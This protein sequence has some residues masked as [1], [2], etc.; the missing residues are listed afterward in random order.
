M[1]SKEFRTNFEERKFSE[2][3]SRRN[4][5]ICSTI[6]ALIEFEVNIQTAASAVEREVTS[7]ILLMISSAAA[8][9]LVI[10][11]LSLGLDKQPSG[12]WTN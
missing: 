6:A 9:F 1:H 7:S 5:R 12:A 11:E 10:F 4:S 3:L 8:S 2:S